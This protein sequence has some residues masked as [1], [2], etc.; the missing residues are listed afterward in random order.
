MNQD[1]LSIWRDDGHLADEAVH[2]LADLEFSLVST[3]ARTHAAGCPEC[4]ARIDNAAM[5]ASFLSERLGQLAICARK[6]ARPAPI[7]AVA[8]ASATGLLAVVAAGRGPLAEAFQVLS[9][10]GFATRTILRALV[11]LSR[12][13]DVLLLLAPALLV[14]VA[15]WI[16]RTSR[17]YQNEE[18]TL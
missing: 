5:A 7:P 18:A 2:A 11:A 8:I 15:L 3:D 17:T 6:E 14:A 9:L 10:A 13:N 12:S 16:A 4:E 1:S